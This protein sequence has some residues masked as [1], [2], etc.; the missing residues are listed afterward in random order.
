ML[1]DMIWKLAQKALRAPPA[2]AFAMR[3]WP[4]LLPTFSHFFLFLRLL[5]FTHKIYA[6]KNIMSALIEGSLKNT[7][8]HLPYSF[9]LLRR[10]VKR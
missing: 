5:L 4:L 2:V 7:L 10:V 6:K 8:L 3:S 1:P 9:L